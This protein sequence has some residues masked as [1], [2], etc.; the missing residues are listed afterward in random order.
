MAHLEKFSK[1]AIGHMLAHYDRGAEHIRNECV[2]RTRSHL[3]Y[4]L[5][6]ELQPDRQGDFIKRRCSEVKVQ[7]RKDVNL[8]CTWIV[9]VPKDLPE[10]EHKQ[11]FKTAFDFMSE[12]YGKENVISAYVH[13]DETTPHMHFAF[14]PV[15]PD[16][17]KKGK[18]KVSAKERINRIELYSFHRDLEKVLSSA[19]GHSVAILNGATKDGNKS[20]TRLKR[21][22]QILAQ[23]EAERQERIAES[24][25]QYA[26][27]RIKAADERIEQARIRTIKAEERAKSEESEVIRQQHTWMDVKKQTD[28][29]WEQQQKIKQ[30]IA[31]L[32]EQ[33]KRAENIKEQTII[34]MAEELTEKL[35]DMNEQI[36]DAEDRLTELKG[37]ILTAEQV[38]DIG[39]KKAPFGMALLP[40]QDA[41]N[42]KRTAER[43]SEVDEKEKQAKKIIK[44]ERTILKNAEQE[45]REQVQNRIREVERELEKKR[46]EKTQSLKDEIEKLQKT[47]EDKQSTVEIKKSTIE[48]YISQIE[49][50]RPIFTSLVKSYALAQQLLAEEK[51][52]KIVSHETMLKKFD[53]T[54]NSYYEQENQKKDDTQSQNHSQSQGRRR[55]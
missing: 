2:D 16:N 14:I 45:G 9:T 1:A 54:K 19:L 26:E 43:V 24:R 40:Y 6:S 38:Q 13:M 53:D 31:T 17:K 27:Q 15:V 28:E 5:A 25:T 34:R 47:I 10:N 21:E 29:L 52:R 20:V 3:N 51:E 33:L 36:K 12:R 41:L 35:S 48:G 39:I 11:F 37:K 42:L 7:N 30:N 22:T 50:F 4:N 18:F 46:K 32:E 8:M 55:R 23:M 49:K 44:N